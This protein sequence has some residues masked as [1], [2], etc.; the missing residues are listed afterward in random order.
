MSDKTLKIERIIKSSPERIWRCI[1]EP[2]L[3]EKW[4]CPKPWFVKDVVQELRIGGISSMKIC[5]PDG[6]EFPNNGIVLEAITNKKLVTTDAFI[7]AWTPSERAFMVATTELEDL[8]D[9]TTKYT[10]SATHWN[11]EARE[12]HI[13]M[14]FYEGWG[15][16]ATQLEEFVATL[17]D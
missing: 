5:G 13:K 1:T 12:E 4:F 10:A 15:T 11:D 14:G 3:M 2:K 16:A 6:E 9:G 7:N 17:E 8:G